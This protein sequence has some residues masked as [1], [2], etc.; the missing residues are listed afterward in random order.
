MEPIRIGGNKNKVEIKNMIDKYFLNSKIEIK[1]KGLEDRF[2]FIFFLEKTRHLDE[3]VLYN[4]LSNLVQDII[5]EIYIDQVIKDRVIKICSDYSTSEKKDIVSF[6]HQM[7]LDT[8]NYVKERIKINDEICDY[9]MEHNSLLIDGYIEFRL[10][11]YLYIIDISIEKAIL[12]LETEKEYMEFLNMLHYFVDIQEPKYELVNVIVKDDD[13][14][15]LDLDNNVI[16]DGLLED[17]E[18]ELLYG[19]IGKVDLLISSLIVISPN[20]LIIHVKDIE[21][22]QQLVDITSEIFKDR[23]KFCQGC[24]QCQVNVK[25][26]NGK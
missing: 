11:D 22:E 4:N 25:L 20:K 6:V 26:K 19:D 8:N 13:Y 14:I 12:D 10:R 17:M 21:K 5:V 15:I 24:E 9:L 23:V 1:E 3:I 7:L 2:E 18:S 16:E